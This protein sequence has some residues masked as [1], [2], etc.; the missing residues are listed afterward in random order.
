MLNKILIGFVVLC[1][2]VGVILSLYSIH[3]LAT[4]EFHIVLAPTLESVTEP[5]IE[6]QPETTISQEELIRSYFQDFIYI[7]NLSEIELE[8]KI[9]ELED[10]ISFLYSFCP[11]SYET[12][13]YVQIYEIISP[14]ITKANGILNLY[15]QDI[16]VYIQAREKEEAHWQKC[17]EEFPIA[18]QVW[19]Y[20]KNEF[21]WS[22][23]VCAGIM[24]NLMAEC[25]GCWTDDLDWQDDGNRS[26]GLVQW[27]SGRRAALFAKYGTLPSVTEQLDFMRDEMYGTNGVTKQLFKEEYLDAIMNAT[28][29][30]DCAYAFAQYF[31]RCNERHWAPR[32]GYARTAYEYFVYQ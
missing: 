6:T 26:F 14:E 3:V 24:G 2:I 28:T 29:P 9:L 11:P 32:R 18:T 16:E 31:E 10:Y 5:T 13:K 23:I 12:D 30:E 19:L 22:D 7:E 1:A 20:M 25:G 15:K 17:A 27:T 4:P 8:E 21:G